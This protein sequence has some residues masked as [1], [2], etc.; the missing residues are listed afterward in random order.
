[1]AKKGSKNDIQNRGTAA[2]LREVNGKAVKPVQYIG[3]HLGHGSYMAAMYVDG[4]KLALG[5]DGKPIAYLQ[6]SA[7]KN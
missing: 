4:G 6:S 3:T 2:R 7:A 5:A 1:M